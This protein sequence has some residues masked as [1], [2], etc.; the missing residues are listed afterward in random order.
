MNFLFEMRF[1]RSNFNCFY[2][3]YLDNGRKA[4]DEVHYKFYP[5]LLTL[6]M[7]SNN[8]E[9][10]F[11]KY[12]AMHHEPSFFF[13]KKK[14]NTKPILMWIVYRKFPSSLLKVKVKQTVETEKFF[15]MKATFKFFS[16]TR[17][18]RY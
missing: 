16:V 3:Y 7:T 15:C 13:K 1:A 6:G 17:L 11:E 18:R 12:N 10:F 9:A 2:W 4:K 5:F 8:T 14:N